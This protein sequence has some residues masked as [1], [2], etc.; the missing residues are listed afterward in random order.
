MHAYWFFSNIPFLEIQVEGELTFDKVQLYYPSRPSVKVLDDFTATFPKG[1]TTALVGSSGS[2]KSSVIGLL[3]RFYSEASQALI[4]D[5]GV[6]LIIRPIC[7][8]DPVAGAIY[9]DGQDISTLNIRWLRSQVGLVSQEPTLFAGSVYDN[10]AYGL[11][12][13]RF[14]YETTEKKKQRV[15][16]ACKVA[17]A[18]TFIRQLS[19]GYDTLVG[20]R[21][22]LLSGGQAQRIAIA[23]AI[24][25]EPPILVLD[26]ATSALDV[27]SERLVQKALNNASI[28]RTT[29]AIA[30]RLSTIADADQIIVM[31]NGK[32]VEKG[33]HASLLGDPN[34][35]YTGLVALQ[36]LR[37]GKEQEKDGDGENTI[38]DDVQEPAPVLARAITAYSNS[39]PA[40]DGA[41]AGSR[42][43]HMPL[44]QIALRLVNLNKGMRWMYALAFFGC[45]ISGTAF[46]VS[47]GENALSGDIAVL[48]HP[49]F[50][51]RTGCLYSLRKPPGNL[52]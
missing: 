35:V 33:T 21:G 11:T 51:S 29:I 12:N 31:S 19:D 40:G 34:G 5:E 22:L 9:L 47:Y 32:I 39:G 23:R 2:G 3:E 49:A 36:S 8:L 42:E 4:V 24:I 37:Q 18:D 27:T 38:A 41:E 52:L 1:R 26:E 17:N 14:D 20:E 16:E 13:T 6:K 15:I 10:V 43:K 44:I 25:A 45:A 7:C 48:R 46:P 50:R 30:H 28:G